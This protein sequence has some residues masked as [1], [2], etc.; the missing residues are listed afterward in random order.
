MW[1]YSDLIEYLRNSNTGIKGQCR[2]YH[3]PATA[4]CGLLRFHVIPSHLLDLYGCETWFVAQRKEYRL[5]C[6]RGV[7]WG[8]YSDPSESN[9]RM[10]RTAQWG[11][12]YAVLFVNVRP[13]RMTKS[14]GVEV[15]EACST[16]GEDDKCIHNF[17]KE[18]SM[19]QTASES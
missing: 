17:S 14:R 13:I 15:G 4:S 11:S 6:M 3:H 18:I 1:K 16:Y 19:K 9:R 10:D 7:C 12:L 8:D 2:C 5:K